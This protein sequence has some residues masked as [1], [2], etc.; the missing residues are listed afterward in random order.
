[1][2]KKA[3]IECCVFCYGQENGKPV[4]VCSACV[5]KIIRASPAAIANLIE[6]YK[7]KLTPDQ[8]HFLQ[9]ATDQEVQYDFKTRKFR[10][11]MDRERVGRTAKPAHPG[12]RQM[13]AA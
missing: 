13:R 2:S 7:D 1:M 12:V 8:L 6:K 4:A 10:K 9:G 3:T 11:D 5:Q